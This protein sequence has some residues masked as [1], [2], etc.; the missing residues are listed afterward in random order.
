MLGNSIFQILAMRF[1]NVKHF[2]ITMKYV[3]ANAYRPRK[4][5]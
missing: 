4:V 2:T 3:Y 5:I 1:A